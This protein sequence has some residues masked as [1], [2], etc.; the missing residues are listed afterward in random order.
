MGRN[1]CPECSIEVKNSD[2]AVYC[3]MCEIWKHL[4]CDV[5]KEETYVAL[6][7]DEAVDPRLHWFC[8]DCNEKA[9]KGI[10]LVL[11]LEKRMKQELAE[12][13]A[14]FDALKQ[15]VTEL[16][17]D[18]SEFKYHD[19][20]VSD[21]LSKTIQDK[22]DATLTTD[23]ER[24]KKLIK[25]EVVIVIAEDPEFVDAEDDISTAELAVEALRVKEREEMTMKN[26]V[27]KLFEEEMSR[28]SAVKVI[29]EETVSKMKEDI[30][31]EVTV[32]EK[33]A[34]IDEGTLT[35]MKDDITNLK[36]V[37]DKQSY[38]AVT[39]QGA[40]STGVVVTDDESEGQW[41]EKYRKQVSKVVQQRIDHGKR[42]KNI[43]LYRV[44]E[45]D[46]RED[47][48]EHDQRMI[49]ELFTVCEVQVKDYIYKRIGSKAEG[50]ARPI[51]LTFNKLE[52]KISL[53]K[54]VSNLKDAPAHIKAISVDHDK[55][56]EERAE[57][58][59]LV[60]KAKEQEQKDPLH[61]Y[62]VRGPPG[63]QRIVQ[64]PL[65]EGVA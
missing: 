33:N 1:T 46:S 54:N 3:E 32:R 37:A 60:A 31:Q 4:K 25:D 24:I 13:Q 19:A 5:V 28:I 21:D 2:K 49:Q 55:T 18:L 30:I 6:N 45:S 29:D 57:T 58:K 22:I 50:K 64:L 63:N 36:A 11:C 35:R 62:R 8:S 41:T 27:K 34:V 51:I 65:L 61:R 20:K 26:E 9:V 38:A 14:A 39:L 56:Q 47:A 12:K 40:D 23:N 7:K 43:I 48:H 53:F 52:Q 44:E 15:E 10:K 16:S 17:I 59:N 42:E